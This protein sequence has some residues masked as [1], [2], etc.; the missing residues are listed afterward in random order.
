LLSIVGAVEVKNAAKLAHQ[1]FRAWQGGPSAAPPPLP[2]PAVDGPRVLLLDGPE[3]TQSQV[4]LGWRGISRLHPDADT[5]LVVNHV[6]GGSFTS[7]LMRAARVKRGLTYGISSHFDM[8]VHGGTFELGTA[9]KVETTREII[10]VSLG[11]IAAYRK[12]PAAAEL[13]AAQ[14]Y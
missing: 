5:A 1:A 13:R 2:P 4:R 9:T 3:L 6:L 12:G 7:R 11:E 8:R 14:R 10:D